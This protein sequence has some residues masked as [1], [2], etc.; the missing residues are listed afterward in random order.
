MAAEVT[1]YSEPCQVIGSSTPQQDKEKKPVD[2]AAVSKS[3]Q[4]K[5]G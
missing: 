4:I 5:V 3:L 2:T 1:S